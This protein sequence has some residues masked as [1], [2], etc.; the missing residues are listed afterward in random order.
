M[1]DAAALPGETIEHSGPY[2]C[3]SCGRIHA[4]LT[5]ITVDQHGHRFIGVALLCDWCEYSWTAVV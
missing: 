2:P 3:P 1:G 4:V 5:T